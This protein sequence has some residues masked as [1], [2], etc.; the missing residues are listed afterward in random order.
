MCT[1]YSYRG[2]VAADK[3]AR[4][5]AIHNI[6]T[7]MIDNLP[8][9]LTPM[10]AKRNESEV[11]FDNPDPFKRDSNPGLASG[12]LTETA[13]DK[14]A[15]KSS[16]RQF[17]HLSEYAFY[18]FAMELDQSVQNSIP[19]AKNTAIWKESTANGMGGDGQS[20]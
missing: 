18:P 16:S 8:K 13:Q 19:L 5:Q 20:F 14:D 12:F 6:Y 4:T 3:F 15:G 2:I 1:Q 11:L 7:T 9:P 17:A 10:I